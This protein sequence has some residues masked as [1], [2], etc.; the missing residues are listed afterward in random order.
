MYQGAKIQIKIFLLMLILGSCSD[1]VKLPPPPPATVPVT[2]EREEES[3]IAPVTSLEKLFVDSG[4]IDIGSIDSGIKVQLAYAT[5]E[6]FLHKDLYEGMNKCY[7]PAEVAEKL[8]KAQ[9]YLKKASPFYN[10]LIFDATRPLHIQRYM[11]DSLR[12][13]YSFKINYLAHPNDISLHNYG[14]AVDLG[15]ITDEAVIAD[16]GTPFDYFGRE[17]HTEFETQLLDSA[18][19]N[20][21]Q[22]SNR[23]LLRRVMRMAGFSTIRTEWWHFNSCSKE[24]AVKKFKLIP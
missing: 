1:H 22:V 16:M 7:L 6:N 9:Q 21:E 18:K 15:L 2:V 10:L 19:L 11:W 5:T 12:L 24:E 3:W 23:L 4:L 8:H 20:Q 14:A 17:A 13:P